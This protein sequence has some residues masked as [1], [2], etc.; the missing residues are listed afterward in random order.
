MC[1]AEEAVGTGVRRWE[2]SAVFQT[3]LMVALAHTGTLP[4]GHCFKGFES[5]ISFNPPCFSQSTFLNEETEAQTE[6]L[7]NVTQLESGRTQVVCF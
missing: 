1:Q 4:A 3:R 2:V 5:V 7:P 6:N